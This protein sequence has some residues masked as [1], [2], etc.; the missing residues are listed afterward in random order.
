MNQQPNPAPDPKDKLLRWTLRF[1]VGLPRVFA[2]L[3]AP[4]LGIPDLGYVT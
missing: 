3:P 2:P 4:G 1:L